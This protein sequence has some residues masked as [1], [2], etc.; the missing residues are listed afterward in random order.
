MD[1][2]HVRGVKGRQPETYQFRLR[3]EISTLALSLADGWS[4]MR[5]LSE[6]PNGLNRAR[7]GAVGA[8]FSIHFRLRSLMRRSISLD[9]SAPQ[10]GMQTLRGRR[11]A[12]FHCLH[13]GFCRDLALRL[14]LKGHWNQNKKQ[15]EP[16]E[17]TTT[18]QGPLLQHVLKESWKKSAAE[19]PGRHQQ[20]FGIP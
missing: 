10:A 11:R 2:P 12:G 19:F 16:G 5:S 18:K 13:V 3:P 20:I 9:K 17:D 4:G 8:K 14:V 15:Q 1:I 6:T 7:L